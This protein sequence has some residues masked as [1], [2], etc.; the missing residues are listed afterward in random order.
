MSDADFAALGPDPVI[1]PHGTREPKADHHKSSGISFTSRPSWLYSEVWYAVAI[2]KKK[3]RGKRQEAKRQ[4]IKSGKRRD[5]R[6]LDIV[7]LQRAKG[8][9][10]SPDQSYASRPLPLLIEPYYWATLPPIAS[11]VNTFTDFITNSYGHEPQLTAK[12]LAYRA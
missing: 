11:A 8:S 6:Y 1:V 5:E 10:D 9:S 7:A 12:P 4:E 3:E 2:E